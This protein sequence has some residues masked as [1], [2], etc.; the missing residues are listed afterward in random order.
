MRTILAVLILAVV[1]LAQQA[2]TNYCRLSVSLG[3]SQP[4]IG[5]TTAPGPHPWL[6]AQGSALAYVWSTGRP[7]Q[8]CWIFA[9]AIPQTIGQAVLPGGIV[10][11]DLATA[12]EVVSFLLPGTYVP[13]TTYPYCATAGVGLPFMVPASGPI[14]VAVQD[15]L[16]DPTEAVGY[17]LS[18]AIYAMR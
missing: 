14:A 15:I 17:R 1:S 6:V 11:L 7:G 13:C 18:A 5:N 3:A 2:S 10:D 9:S 8:A 12:A 4:S 16:T